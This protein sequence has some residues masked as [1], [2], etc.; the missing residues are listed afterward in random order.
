M[1]QSIIINEK[2]FSFLHKKLKNS[3]PI[4]ESI[5]ITDWLSPDERYVIFLDE[6]YDLK[7]KKNLGDIWENFDNF[8]LFLTHSFRQSSNLPRNIRESC[9]RG[10]KKMVINE[11]NQNYSHLKPIV[12][13]LIK[14][15][16]GF[17]DNAWEKTKE[18]GKDLWAGTK[19]MG[20][21]LYQGTKDF[22]SAI[23]KGDYKEALRIIG[24]GVLYLA[25][26]IRSALHNPVGLI[27]DTILVIS[28]IGKTIQ[29]IP[30]AIVVALDI[31]ELSTGDY[32]D[33]TQRQWVRILLFSCDVLGLVV[34]GLVATG[35]MKFILKNAL[36]YATMSAFL[37]GI[38]NDNEGQQHLRLMEQTYQNNSWLSRMGGAE[39]YVTE[40][41]PRIGGFIGEQ[42]N[43]AGILPKLFNQEVQQPA[44][45][46]MQSPNYGDTRIGFKPNT[47]QPL[48][49][50]KPSL[51]RD[52][53][54]SIGIMK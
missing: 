51:F 39:Q 19:K 34:S 16:E 20:S 26:K 24:K 27:L 41:N 54:K 48:E 12:K 7:E 10:L 6:L 35:A 28:G 50:N 18:F 22:G 13:R 5:V 31:Y 29:W 49:N 30:W 11:S 25:R 2:Q 37:K 1:K 9:L 47:P 8:K 32:E 14:E 3:P 38:R 44:M 36:K 15:G 45:E 53:F 23:S 46:L 40:R 17:W 42:K 52:I 4:S 43:N 33:K 21:D